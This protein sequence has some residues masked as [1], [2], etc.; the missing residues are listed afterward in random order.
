LLV[1][2]AQSTPRPIA[3]SGIDVNAS[4]KPQS[5]K[6]PD[7]AT[8]VQQ[9]DMSRLP[10]SFTANVGQFDKSIKFQTNSLGG[11]IYF[12][13]SEVLLALIDKKVKLKNE[14][15]ESA[16]P[17]VDNSK[18]L[19]IQYL[20]T[21]KDPLVE[22]L[23]QLPGV[24]NFMVGVDTKSW[25]TDA[26]TYDGIV[27]RNIYSGIDLT[28]VGAGNSL[29]STFIVAAGA[30]P[31]SITWSYKDAG[32]VSLDADGNLLINLPAKK[33][34][35]T[36]TV[37]IEYAPTAWQ[38]QDGQRVDVPVQY[39]ISAKSEIG[40]S[41]PQGF[42]PALPLTIDP[43]LSY[44][45][46]LGNVG[47][48]KGTSI[49]TD[50][51]GNA[52]VT[53]YTYCSN[54]PLV[55]PIPGGAAGG[56]DV[57]ISKISADGS[58]L[59][60]STCLGG[61]GDDD[62][63][64]IA[65]DNQ[66]RVVVSGDTSSTDFP[67]VGGIATYGGTTGLCGV[68]APC[69]DMFVLGLNA[70][71]NAIRYSTFLG[72]DGQDVLGDM[73]VNASDEIVVVGY[74][75]ST[76]FP[77][78]NAYDSTYAAGGT[79]SATVPCYD[80]TVTRI[81]SNLTGANAIRYSTYMGGIN[82]DRAFGVTLDSNGIAYF[83]G[84]TQ[85]TDYPTQN[86]FQSTFMGNYDMIVTAIDTSLS[87]NAS[88]V[89]STFFGTPTYETGYDI[90]RDASGNLYITGRTTSGKYPLR[91]PVQYLSHAGVNCNGSACY[92]AFVTKL[93]ITTNTL[94]YSTYLGGGQDDEGHGIAVDSYGRAYVTGFTRSSDFPV[95]DPIQA[96]KG[97]DGCAAPPCADAFLSVLEPNGQAFAYSTFLGGDQDDISNGIR[98]DGNNNVYIVGES[99]STNFPTTP[100]AY[101]VVNTQ[102]DKRD[103]FIAKVAALGAPVAQT[104]S[105]LDIPIIASS[106]DAEESASGTMDLTSTDLELVQESTTQ[107]VG[108]RF[109]GVN[110]PRGATI[111]SASIQ[112]M[113]D[114][115][116][117][118]TT[119]LTIQ[120]Q[121]ADNAPT[122]T[123]TANNISSR[124][125]T[126]ASV[127]W[128]PAAWSTTDQA[129]PAQ[130]TSNIASVIQEVVNRA[131]W[132]PGNAIA[133]IITGSGKRVATAYETYIYGAPY[134]HIEYT[135]GAPVPT[136]TP[137]PTATSTSTPTS[138]PTATNTPTSTPTDTAT[139]TATATPTATATF[140]P[141]A[142][143]SG[144]VTI[145]YSYD[146]LN[147]LVA[148]DYLT[149]DYYHYEYDAVGNRLEQ[150][151]L[152]A[153]VASTTTYVP[154][155]AN[156]LSTV[157][158]VAYSFDA[159]GNLLNDGVNT[160]TYD[161]VNRLKTLTGSSVSTGYA[162][163][164]LGDR[165]Q[166]T[167]NGQTT[168]FTMDLNTGLTQALSDGTNTYI[169]GVGRI[170]QVNT[171]TE[172]FLS[173]A[174]GS[175]RQ[176]ADAGGVITYARA[177]DPY[178]VVTA[179]GGTSQSAY[180]FTNEYTSQGLIYLRSRYYSSETG[181][182]LTRDTWRGDVNDPL[183]LN[184]WNYVSGNP[185]NATDPT[186]LCEEIGDE[187]CWGVY[188]E[189]IRWRP[190][191]ANATIL[192]SHG[193]W[194]PLHKASYERLKYYLENNLW[195][196]LTTPETGAIN[197]AFKSS[198][199]AIAWVDHHRTEIIG[200]AQRH[201]LPPEL[202]A[203]VLASEIDFDYQLADLL[204]DT[205]LLI[206]GENAIAYYLLIWPDPGPGVASMHFSTWK[207]IYQYYLDCG[208]DLGPT[209][210]PGGQT[211]SQYQW[212]LTLLTS[213][214]SIE[215]ASALTRLLADYR[216]GS[217]GQPN[218]TTHYNDL[219]FVDMA[220][221]FGAYRA[222]VAGLTCPYVDNDNDGY[223]DC[224][225]QSI[226]NFQIQ[227]GLGD[228][229]RQAYPY[230]E[231]FQRYFE[232]YHRQGE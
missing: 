203:G 191:L 110:I 134:L 137:T 66:G 170:A 46:Y 19:R 34:G 111:V 128:T 81:D 1:T 126:T 185:I 63:V 204:I 58:T 160:Y 68:D 168:T 171:G 162:Y 158:G 141:T 21:E 132:N 144:P 119:S 98:V 53:G 201:G 70:A 130:R 37:L 127:A 9:I 113:V 166:E 226:D 97:A 223:Y 229:A 194:I 15:D 28:Y 83:T 146:P 41:F 65:L 60:F 20:N 5:P 172:Y 180:G 175:V 23:N 87:G 202:V 211:L 118:G 179:T 182:F 103:A 197:Y 188:E 155:D 129:G 225:F 75:T 116:N 167:L 131:G 73:A 164:G 96:A 176:L 101:D 120:A 24:A 4:Y 140:T 117:T 106:D 26:A 147:R 177:Y 8:P 86:A 69:Q 186:G 187:A 90:A 193:E 217:G 148:A 40:F 216:T 45:T 231:F 72:G 77:T 165:L 183:S 12:A 10:L 199:D 76:N 152:L 3:S 52:Y 43:T 153:G 218:K 32:N 184:K 190:D 222:G 213:S 123:S 74:T 151:T 133:I 178:G 67:I 82:R 224:G 80:V 142:I 161:A 105:H 94:V 219:S 38:E 135:V 192:D 139:S 79:C 39:T 35:Q 154:D 62:G 122:F 33:K 100:G 208:Y 54:F 149:G 108:L 189:I 230:F 205:E 17:A 124:I 210:A 92:E 145:N 221:I 181:R 104:S 42:D 25:V 13:S 121:A 99:Y 200:A 95:A 109:T 91:D 220:Q 173:D 136:D 18:F 64:S 56:W 102:T 169:Y 11:S 61:S 31:S 51:A 93:N 27:Y 47:T 22:G 150:N 49:T 88:L 228:E 36:D 209:L 125:K 78:A 16:S 89:Y 207:I 115:L 44:S 71:G 107:K 57:I 85:S 214:G 2:N 7:V 198:C 29:K 138:T 112:F 212:I 156:R 114:E 30:D 48:D 227:P 157:N 55:N 14:D 143:P 163:N 174:L 215:G 196:C 6:L 195:S 84:Y 159:N 206:G 232:Y 59:L 50:A